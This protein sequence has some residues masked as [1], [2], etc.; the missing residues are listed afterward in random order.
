[1]SRWS[2]ETLFRDTKQFAGLEARQCRVDQAMVRHISLVL[3]TIVVLQMIRQNSGESVGSVIGSLLLVDI[4]IE[5][6][7]R[8][9]PTEQL[10]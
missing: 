2:T 7:C 8:K 6:F 9:Q 4:E 3:L 5:P 10:L 1:M